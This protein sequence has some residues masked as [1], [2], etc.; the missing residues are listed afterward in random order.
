MKKDYSKNH[1]KDYQAL[2]EK[3]EASKLENKELKELIRDLKAIAAS[4]IE[5]K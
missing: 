3:Y 1:E 5:I 4:T 2:Y